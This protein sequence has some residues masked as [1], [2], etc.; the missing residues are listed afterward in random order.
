MYDEIASDMDW[1]ADNDART[2][3]D[4]EIIK[5]DANRMIKAQAAAKRIAER[6]AKENMSLLNI[7]AGKIAYPNSPN[8]GG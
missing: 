4:A 7:A 1:E 5:N 2:L 6:N 3:A 8:M